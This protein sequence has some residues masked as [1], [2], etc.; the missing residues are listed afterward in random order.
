MS[1]LRAGVCRIHSLHDIVKKYSSLFL[2]V[3]SKQFAYSSDLPPFRISDASP[4][5]GLYSRSSFKFNGA[6]DSSL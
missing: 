2:G 4:Y 5:Y 6:V 1:R 3:A